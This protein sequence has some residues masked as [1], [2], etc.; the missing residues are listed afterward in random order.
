MRTKAAVAAQETMA[1][2]VRWPV[3][4]HEA[5]GGELV[6]YALRA[7]RCVEL[8]MQRKTKRRSEVKALVDEGERGTETAKLG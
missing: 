7:L 2:W 6:E 8:G 3:E 1:R 4:M 5:V